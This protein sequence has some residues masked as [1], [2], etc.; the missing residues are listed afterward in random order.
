MNSECPPNNS[1]CSPPHALLTYD[2]HQPNLHL[3]N[4]ITEKYTVVFIHGWSGSRHYFDAAVEALRRRAPE[5][6]II[7]YDHRFHGD[8]SREGEPSIAQLVRDLRD[9]LLALC[10]LEGNERIVLIGGSMGASLIWKYLDEYGRDLGS[11]RI[12]GAV[13]IDQAPLQ[14]ASLASGWGPPFHSKGCYDET[15]LDGLIQTVSM[16]LDRLAEANFNSCIHVPERRLP[17]GTREFLARETMKCDAGGLIALMREHTAMDHRDRIRTLKRSDVDCLNMVGAESGVFPREGGLWAGRA[18]PSAITN[19]LFEKASHW[20]YIE[21]P[22]RFVDVVLD[23]F[24]LAPR[25][26]YS[27]GIAYRVDRLLPPPSP[28]ASSSSSNQQQ[29]NPIMVVGTPLPP[30][31]LIISCS[32]NGFFK[33]FFS[34][35]FE[36][37][38]GLVL[39]SPPRCRATTRRGGGL[40]RS[41]RPWRDGTCTMRR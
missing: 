4:R 30:S 12:M 16:G 17:P 32:G 37:M 35:V 8:S 13:F 10:S 26:S 20:L 2:D 24:H 34:F 14:N 11:A 33:E 41:H 21:Y 22:S 38:R 36:E 6:R 9:L 25:F 19:V 40:P 23:H 1:P 31:A 3:I 18:N 15:T 7:A 39:P 29:A 27:R 5:L 28:S